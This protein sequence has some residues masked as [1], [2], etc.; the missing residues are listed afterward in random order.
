MK[1]IFTALIATLSFVACSDKH[2]ADA[3]GNFEAVEVIVSADAA[4]KLLEFNIDEGY[5]L[6]RGEIIGW[7]DT[8]QMVF[9]RDRL[10]AQIAA[11]RAQIPD[12]D[13]LIAS[14][15]EQLAKQRNELKRYQSLVKADAATVQQVEN[16]GYDVRVTDG[17]IRA[18]E[19]ELSTQTK[20][21][22]AQMEPI[23]T[24]IFAIQDRINNAYVVNPIRGTVLAKYAEQ[25]ELASIGKPLYKISN[26]DTLI[27][28]AYIAEPQLS[29]VAIGQ[30]VRVAVDSGDSLRS[31]T[32]RL[33]WVASQAEFTPKVIQTKDER[34]NLVYALKI[35][36]ANDGSLKI[37]MPAEVYFK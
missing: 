16:L 30:R 14:L 33:G 2:T 1:N 18:K 25:H 24:Q 6:H 22:L 31:Y 34:V 17:Q 29:T 4:G 11:L 28:R 21:I 36:V 5:S 32:G 26:L 3:Y 15:Y 13:A 20:S 8:A 37:G 12:K 23:R 9:E 7:I 10:Q 35:Y 19:S 27:L